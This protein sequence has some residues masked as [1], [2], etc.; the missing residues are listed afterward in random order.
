MAA[1]VTLKTKDEPARGLLNP[2]TGEQK[3]RLARYLPAEDVGRWVEHY[4]L[5]AWNLGDEAPYRSENL[6]YPSVHLV[7]ESGNT[8]IWGVVSGK[9]TRVLA[10]AGRVLG[11]KFRPGA[12]YPLVKSPVSRFTDATFSLE[13]VL[14]V[15]SRPLEQAI[16]ASD[17][18]SQM[19]TIAENFIRAHLPAPDD[20][21]EIINQIINGISADRTITKVAD[22]VARC[23][24]SKRTLQRLFS[25]YVGVSPKW[26]IKRYRLHEAVEQLANGEV[27]DWPRLALDLGYFDQAHFIKDFKML[28]GTPPGEY[29]RGVEIA[30]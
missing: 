3:F 11:I 23:H 6:P 1:C 15:D 21:V 2:Q 29:A 14:G 10:G 13:A 12:F 22:V 30:S 9:F 28:V 8:R 19:V 27:V 17:D 26:V 18:D 16:F 7:F 5:V 24:L 20:T 4:W 25:Q